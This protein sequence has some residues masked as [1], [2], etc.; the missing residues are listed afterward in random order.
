M[1]P[2][3]SILSFFWFSGAHRS[4]SL[5]SAVRFSSLS[6]VLS[7]FRLVPLDVECFARVLGA[8]TSSCGSP[9][10]QVFLPCRQCACAL[11]RLPLQLGFLRVSSTGSSP[12]RPR[13]ERRHGQAG[14]GVPCADRHAACGPA[15]AS[16]QQRGRRREQAGRGVPG[17][18]LAGSGKRHVQKRAQGRWAGN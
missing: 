2:W 18:H 1:F 12:R 9:R 4:P 15:A 8:R 17:G 11:L 5:A 7:G 3:P 14:R 16:L 6:L 13:R 10:F